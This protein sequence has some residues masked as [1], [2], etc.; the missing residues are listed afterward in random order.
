MANEI[1]GDKDA[2]ISGWEEIPTRDSPSARRQEDGSEFVG[3]ES[4]FINFCR[5]VD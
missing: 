1:G 3:I 4:K 5:T 2:R